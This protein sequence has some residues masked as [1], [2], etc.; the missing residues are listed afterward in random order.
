MVGLRVLEI[1]FFLYFI[2]FIPVFL[3]FD[4]QGVFP[5]SYYPQPLRQIL[6]DYAIN[7]RDPLLVD[8]PAWFHAILFCEIFMQLPFL[9]VAAYAFYKGGQRW[10]RVPVIMYATHVATTDLVICSHFMWHDFSNS[11][12]PSPSTQGQRSLLL[13]VYSPFLLVPL[14]MLLTMCCSHTYCGSLPQDRKVKRR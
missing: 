7:Y 9:P 13:A 6:G 11:T 1:C 3:L 14:L 10:I 4:S 12:H 8:P 2:A 5:A